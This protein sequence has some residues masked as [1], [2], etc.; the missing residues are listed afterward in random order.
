[1]HDEMEI[2]FAINLKF[3]K[4]VKPRWSFTKKVTVHAVRRIP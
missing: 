2:K 1:M 3:V 4:Y